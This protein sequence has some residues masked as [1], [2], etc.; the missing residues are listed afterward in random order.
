MKIIVAGTNDVAL[1]IADVLSHQYNVVLIGPDNPRASKLIG[2][3]NIKFYNAS[4]V[5]QETLLAAG[6]DSA[7]VFVASTLTDE[8]NLIAC[9]NARGIRPKSYDNENHLSI[10]CLLIRPHFSGIA[11]FNENLINSLDID[12]IIHPSDELAQEIV[13]IADIQ[14][15]LDVQVFEQSQVY[16]VKVRV[17]EQATMI[18]RK[19]RHLPLPNNLIFVL[20]KNS[21]GEIFIPNGES[22]FYEDYTVTVMG[23]LKDIETFIYEMA[24]REDYRKLPKIVT[25]VGGGSVGNNV[26]RLLAQEEWDVRVIEQDKDIIENSCTENNPIYFWGDGTDIDFL[27]KCRVEESSL[28]IAVTNSD[29]RNLLVSLLGQ[30]IGVERI[31]TRADRLSNEKVFEEIGVDVVRSAR[32]AAIRKV[33]HQLIE[34]KPVRTELEHGDFQLIEMTLPERFLN[35]KVLELPQKPAFVIGA[36][37]RNKHAFIPSGTT[38][39]HPKDKLLVI[40]DENDAE[41]VRYIL[42]G[43][44]TEG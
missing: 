6:I 22:V 21:E 31:I 27:N 1:N 37:I 10:V 34:D 7:Q 39:L 38:E 2:E 11:D 17:E 33:V 43:S 13:Q 25:I 14:G 8:R 5:D 36:V 35:K 16:L 9:L 24:F 18:G 15:A 44:R 42:T 28:L 40:V 3:D 26:A 19:V 41:E 4:S 20:G 29:E 23:Y 30:Y 12:S 32:G